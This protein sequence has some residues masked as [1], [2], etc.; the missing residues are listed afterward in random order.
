MSFHLHGIGDSDSAGRADAIDTVVRGTLMEYRR[1]VATRFGGP[2][3]LQVVEEELPE[4]EP[5]ELRIRV[6]PAGVS[7]A[8]LLMRE[9]VHPETLQPPFTPFWERRAFDN[10]L[11][12]Q[13][14]M[15]RQARQAPDHQGLL[16]CGVERLSSQLMR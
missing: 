7:Y 2:E 13:T 6:L 8:D 11:G 4:P 1:I 5:G 3:V 12:L 14:K 15:A 9:G 16:V 10:G